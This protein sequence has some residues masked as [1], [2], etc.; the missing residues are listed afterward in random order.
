MLGS[1]IA[2]SLSPVLH[3]AAYDALGLDWAYDAVECDEAGLPAL[4]DRLGPE[5]AGLS[6]TMPLKAVVLPLLD[7]VTPLAVAVEAANTVV[8]RDGCRHGDNTDVPGMVRALSDAGI[9][10]GESPVVLGAGG[11]ARSALA[12]LADLGARDVAVVVR[13]RARAR[14]LAAAGERL[15]TRVTL[16]AWPG[17]AALREATLV[18]STVPAGAADAVAAGGW[19][20]DLPLFDVLYHP[21]PTPLA[22]AALA[23]GARV[24][25]GLDLLV[26]QAVLQVE[27]M[28]GRR[29]PAGVLAAAGREALAARGSQRR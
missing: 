12:A 29:P 10:P 28:T 8:F 11:T 20:G 1:P 14:P 23:A 26:S 19:R 9:A 7:T 4:L 22:A 24:V 25:P 27:L 13:E 18:V 2:H 21:W 3:R 5:Y 16:T 6:L 15:G 17:V